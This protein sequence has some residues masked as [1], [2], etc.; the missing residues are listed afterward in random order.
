[1]EENKLNLTADKAKWNKKKNH[2]LL[3]KKMCKDGLKGK[4]EEEEAEEKLNAQC[5]L[6]R[7]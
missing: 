5:F 7:M 4:E 1:M 2:S 3:F 6:M